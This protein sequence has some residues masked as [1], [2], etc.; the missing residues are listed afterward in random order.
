MKATGIVRKLDRLGRLV[1]PMELRRVMN[2]NDKDPVEIFVEGNDIILRKFG[3]KCVLCN[4]D[5]DSSHAVVEGKHIC[6][7]CVGKIN[8]IKEKRYDK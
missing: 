5:F 7:K 1:I 3:S 8:R 4:S 2:I 6:F